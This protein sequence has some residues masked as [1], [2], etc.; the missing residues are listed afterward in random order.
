MPCG[1][2]W[3]IDRNG[4]VI[5]NEYLVNM[6]YIGNNGCGEGSANCDWND[7]TVY[8]IN[9]R[10][11]DN[12]SAIAIPNFTTNVNKESF[13]AVNGSFD[14]GYAGNKLTYSTSLVGGGRVPSWLKL[15][16]RTGVFTMKAPTADLGKVYDIEVSVR[17]LNGLAAR[18]SFTLLVDDAS[19]KC[20]VSAN[21]DNQPKVLDCSSGRVRLNGKTSSKNYRWSGPGGFT[22]TDD[23]P[24]VSRPGT[25]V[26][27]DGSSCGRASGGGVRPRYV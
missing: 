9:V 18:S 27:R 25:Y 19:L 21:A 17:D 26:L 16:S 6:D 14:R 11:A 2:I 13:Y 8:L 5:P 10:P 23:K 24:E 12:P 3:A 22:S 4:K 15:D 20:E 7:N 1:L